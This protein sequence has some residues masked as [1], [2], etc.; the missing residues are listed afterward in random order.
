V[1]WFVV[2]LVATVLVAFVVISRFS[3]DE[4]HEPDEGHLE[5]MLDP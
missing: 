3:E 2:A 1:T 5:D 4:E